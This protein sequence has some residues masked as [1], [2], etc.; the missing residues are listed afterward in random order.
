VARRGR[1]HGFAVARL[2][3]TAEA[4]QAAV[5]ASWLA[6]RERT[7]CRRCKDVIG[8]YEPMVVLADGHTRETSAAREPEAFASD[9]EC[10]HR[11]CFE[12][13]QAERPAE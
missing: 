4:S 2:R 3:D 5:C 13:M 12:E 10:Y 1:L 8:V 6:V 9:H 11:V 7:A